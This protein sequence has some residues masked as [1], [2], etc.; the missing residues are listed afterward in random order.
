MWRDWESATSLLGRHVHVN[1]CWLYGRFLSE[2]P[3]PEVVSCVYWAE[4]AAQ[5]GDKALRR[6]PNAE[7]SRRTDLLLR[8]SPGPGSIILT[9]TP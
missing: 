4:G 7:V 5:Q 9:V 1:A 2:E 6:Q 8:A 3:E